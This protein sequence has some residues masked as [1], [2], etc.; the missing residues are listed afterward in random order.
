M[1]LDGPALQRAKAVALRY[2]AASAR[3]EAQLRA[4]LEKDGLGAPAD[5]VVEWLRQL[6]YLDDDAYARSR[7]R[8]LVASGR[9][10]PRVAERRLQRA[11]IEAGVAR[12]AVAGALSEEVPGGELALCRALAERR[13]RGTPLAGLDAR[14]RGRLA[15]F[16][17]GRGFSSAAVAR[18]LGGFE[19]RDLDEP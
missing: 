10:G 19:D 13:A 17:L 18:V 15:R 12:A 9:L 8:A 4:R 11:G 16:L 7:A 14:A 5:A 6:R 3:T 2:L 1:T